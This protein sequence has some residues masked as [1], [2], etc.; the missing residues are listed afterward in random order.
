MALPISESVVTL[1][2]FTSGM[3]ANTT[4]CATLALQL[5]PIWKILFTKLAVWAMTR[6][7]SLKNQ[8]EQLY[9]IRRRLE[10]Y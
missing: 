10:V 2:Q 3:A 8:L 1:S 7:N 5:H 6:H 9:T 4:Y